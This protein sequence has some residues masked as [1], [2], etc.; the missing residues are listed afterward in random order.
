MLFIGLILSGIASVSQGAI[1]LTG[2]T[3]TFAWN[4]SAGAEGYC[5]VYAP[6]DSEPFEGPFTGKI[7]VGDRTRVSFEIWQGAGFHV[8]VQ[9]YNEVGTSQ[10]SNVVSFVRPLVAPVIQPRLDIRA[11]GSE[12]HLV[13]PESAPVTLSLDLDQVGRD[14]AIPDIWIVADTPL[15]FYSFRGTDGWVEGI[16]RYE[17]MFPGGAANFEIPSLYLPVGDYTF[18]L[19][20][21]DDADRLPDGTW[22]EAIRVEVVESSSWWSPVSDTYSYW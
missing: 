14:N 20:V 13:V 2:S 7:D 18:Y 1:T 12:S 3:V 22:W 16:H 15:G 5:V 17:E 11:N 4:P 6:Y 19:A 8:A 21:D 9:A 10:V